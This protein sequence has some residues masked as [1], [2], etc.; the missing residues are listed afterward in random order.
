MSITN[1]AVPH[2]VRR[3][4]QSTCWCTKTTSAH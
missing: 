4:S 1:T 2:L 3:Q